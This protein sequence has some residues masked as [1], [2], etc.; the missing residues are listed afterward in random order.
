M[1]KNDTF[2]IKVLLLLGL[3]FSL[4]GLAVGLWLP[5]VVQG[6]ET[7]VSSLTPLTF[8]Q[9]QE[10]AVGTTILLEGN[11]SPD[12]LQ[13]DGL[14]AYNTYRR[15]GDE[16]V[17][18]GSHTPPFAVRIA[19]GLA[20]VQNTTYQLTRTSH[21]VRSGN[22]EYSGLARYDPVVIIGTLAD[23]G[24]APTINAITV[25]FG[26]HADQLAELIRARQV[27][28]WVGWVVGAIGAVLLVMAIIFWLNQP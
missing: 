25:A 7:A 26:T 16:S 21:N 3:I 8:A 13:Q 4:S 5:T 12:N 28:T 20:Y 2:P 1:R 18:I 6:E 24:K 11:I 22:I 19:G 9:L 10:T 23:P 17:H 27:W 15:S 14:V